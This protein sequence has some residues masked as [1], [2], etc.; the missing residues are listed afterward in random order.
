MLEWRMI[1][2]ERKR[3]EKRKTEYVCVCVKREG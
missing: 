3:R 2:V 1:G